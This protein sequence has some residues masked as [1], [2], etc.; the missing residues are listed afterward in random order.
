VR[1]PPSG[2]DREGVGAHWPC[3]VCQQAGN[4]DPA[5]RELWEGARVEAASAGSRLFVDAVIL[6]LRQPQPDEFGD[7]NPNDKVQMSGW[8]CLWLAK[9]RF[10]I[11]SFQVH[12]A[13]EIIRFEY[14]KSEVYA[15]MFLLF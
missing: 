3:A 6:K 8:L 5:G 1:P 13:N 9:P 10:I 15:F 12:V 2:V 7:F 11:I 4:R 14:S